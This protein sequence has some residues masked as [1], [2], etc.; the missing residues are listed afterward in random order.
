MDLAGVPGRLNQALKEFTAEIH[1]TSLPTRD[2]AKSKLLEPTVAQVLKGQV[3]HRTVIDADAR[4]TAVGNGEAQ[5]YGRQPR[6][7]DELGRPA[8]LDACQNPIPVPVF[9]PGR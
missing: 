3:D 6:P 2:R 8:I 4:Q 5:V 7:T 9:Q 1:P